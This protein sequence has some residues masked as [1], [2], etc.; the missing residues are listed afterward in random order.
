[1]NDLLKHYA[2]KEASHK[3]HV[4]S[5]L[6]QMSIIK[7]IYKDTKQWLPKTGKVASVDRKWDG[8]LVTVKGYMVSFWDNEN[9]LKSIM[10]MDA[11]LCKY[12]TNY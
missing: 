4:L 1:M 2:K 6:Y 11:Q 7:Q 10:A 5:H 12:T 8:V 3:D 9:F